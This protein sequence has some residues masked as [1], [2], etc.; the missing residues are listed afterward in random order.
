MIRLQA[1]RYLVAGIATAIATTPFF[2]HTAQAHEHHM[3]SIPDGKGI[4]D[5][6]IVRGLASRFS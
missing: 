4:S 5:A 2:V 6:P 1:S 3:D